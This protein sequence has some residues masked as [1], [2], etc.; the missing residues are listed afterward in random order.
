MK[1]KIDKEELLSALQK[2]KNATEK[3]SALPILNNFLLVAEDG[4]LTVKAT[5]LENFLTFTVRANV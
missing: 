2:A 1:L 4:R 5:D 3:K